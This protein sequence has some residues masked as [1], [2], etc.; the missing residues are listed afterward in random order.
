MIIVRPQIP[1]TDLRGVL[2]ADGDSPGGAA[3]GSL[4][5]VPTAKIEPGQSGIAEI[6][7]GEE[8]L[9]AVTG[10]HSAVARENMPLIP[11]R[12]SSTRSRRL[13]LHD[14]ALTMGAE[15]ATMV[16]SL[17]LT[18]LLG[19]WMGARQLS[20]Y[21]LL[22][23]VLSWSVAAILLGLATGLPRYVA[24]SA[25]STERKEPVYF[26]A[27]LVCMI[28]TASVVG[29][30]MIFNRVA[31]ARWFFGEA[32]ESGMV[33]ALALLLI[34][35]SIHNAVYG[36]Y[37]GQLDM[38]RANLLEVAN[39]SILPL[40]IVT[41]LAHSHTVSFMMGLCGALMAFSAALFAV[42]VLRLLP[43]V[44]RIALGARCRELLWYGVPRVP[45]EFGAAAI[46][47]LGPMLAAHYLK[48]AR[49]SPL[50]LGLNILLVIGY[51]AGPLGVVLLSKLGMMLS[52]N[53][54]EAVQDRLRL[55]VACVVE[56][57]VFACFQL[58]VFADVVVRTWVGP[59]FE[60]D[61]GVIRLVLLAIPP[62]LF[63]MTLR[64]TIDAV[65]VKPYNTANVMSSLAV[66]VGL[67]MAWIRFLPGRSLLFGIAVSLFTSQLLLALLTAR[68]FRRFYGLG[69][70]WRQLWPS[71]LSAFLLGCVAFVF[72]LWR[73]APMP[74]IEAAG[75]E[76]IFVAA[77]LGVLARLGSG[78]LAY[79]WHVGIRRC[80]D[81]SVSELQNGGAA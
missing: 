77:Y 19:R 23:R 68:T 2:P 16:S 26:L 54:Q 15:V 56:L 60:S 31:F 6:V 49:I 53:Q 55:L 74:A 78:W 67:I 61:M 41:L 65:T 43:G 45:G 38:A 62:Y 37:R 73:S 48:L 1:V 59:G 50:L 7:S 30:V 25:G 28:P 4:T 5:E 17:L 46:T 51:A 72:R 27:A 40:A 18:A 44:P 8:H 42:P 14:V 39:A 21:L 80:T 71:F 20:E 69:I 57:S 36:Y 76:I 58:A 35:F 52:Q 64:S 29:A 34:G 13:F 79:A 32:Q 24:Y 47:A 10:D 12:S 3:S 33:I 11:A 22:R 75:A 81:W 70:P 63:F 9:A 66:Y